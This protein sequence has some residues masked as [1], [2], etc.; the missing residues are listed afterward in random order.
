[1]APS[2]AAATISYQ[3]PGTQPPIFVAGT[4][5]EPQWEPHEMDY[6]TEEEGEHVFKKEIF[7]EPGSKIQYKFRVGSGNWWVLDEGSP[8]ATDS[9]GNTNNEMKNELFIADLPMLSST[10]GKAEQSVPRKKT[11]NG[12]AVMNSSVAMNGDAI[13]P[14]NTSFGDGRSQP[15]EKPVD[16]RLNRL[17]PDSRSATGTPNF[18]SVA[19]EVADTAAI[20]N[21]EAPE[22]QITDEEAGKIGFRRLSSTPIIEVANTAAEVADTARDLD[23]VEPVVGFRILS[24]DSSPFGTTAQNESFLG[25]Q[26]ELMEHK[27]PLFAHECIGMYNDDEDS[28]AND[29][30]DS[31]HSEIRVAED[32]VDPDKIDVN[33]PTLEPFPSNREE[34]IN[35]VR[36]LE[37]GLGEDQASFEGTPLS[38][39]VGLHRRGTEDFT[40]DFLLASPIPAEEPS[41]AEFRN[42]PVVLLSEPRR[43]SDYKSPLSDEDEGVAMKD[44]RRPSTP[45]LENGGLLTPEAAP[46]RHIVSHASS[47][48]GSD[49]LKVEGRP[50]QEQATPQTPESTTPDGGP[51]ESPRIVIESAEEVNETAGEATRSSDQHVQHNVDEDAEASQ[52]ANGVDGIAGKRT[53]TAVDES[54]T[55]PAQL[56]KRAARGESSETQASIHSAAMPP[57]DH[58]AGWIKAFF[59]L[60]FIDWIGGFISRLCGGR[61]RT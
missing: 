15:V 50:D 33:D 28:R 57:P 18:A 7:V 36:K 6:T 27:A 26:D 41:P 19:A 5:S 42:A 32:D 55:N 58:E 52:P 43:R 53:T 39:V 54:T 35:T 17:N 12:S 56:R 48:P 1:M 8:T 9:S 31:D 38:P 10:K 40:G 24:D 20:L 14:K 51:S 61:R 46:P 34:I 44:S 2:K 13:S 3:K 59:R 11:I 16:A 21:K 60:L 22:T 4:F 47:D 23:S 37:T 25:D 29:F 49:A 45:K 30:H